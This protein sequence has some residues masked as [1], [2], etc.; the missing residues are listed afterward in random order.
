M[1][2]LQVV[3]GN[4]N[5]ISNGQA[6]RQIEIT[7]AVVTVN[8][9]RAPDGLVASQLGGGYESAQFIRQMTGFIRAKHLALFST[10]EADWYAKQ[11]LPVNKT[12][13]LTSMTEPKDGQTVREN[14]F[15][16]A[17]ASD[18]FGVTRVEFVLRGQS[19]AQAVIGRGLVTGYGWLEA[20]D[21]E[22]VPDGIYTLRSVAYAPGGL[23]SES[24]WIRVKVAN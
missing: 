12:P 2:G 18:P 6:Y 3:L 15:L 24:P 16:F 8:I 14:E 20:W 13:P 10:S 17:T 23:A 9:R 22:K 7:D 19:G 4:G 21:T 5:G 1:I 11:A